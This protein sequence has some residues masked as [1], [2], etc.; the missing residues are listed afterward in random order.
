MPNDAWNF[1]IDVGGTFTD[2][3]ARRP[4]GAVVTHKVLSSGRVKGRVEA[5]DGAALRDG[6]RRGETDGLYAGY[7]F[8]LLD[9]EGRERAQARV[10]AFDGS[11]GTLRLD[12]QLDAMPGDSYE[13]CSGEPAPVLAIRQL[14]G[15]RLG[16]D[17]GAID[18]RLGT[19]RGTNALLERKGAPTAFVTTLGFADILHIG[20]QDRPHLFKLKIEKSEA[21]FRESVELDERLDAGG[22]VLKALDRDEVERKLRPLKARGI[23]ALAVCLLHAYRNPAHEEL[24]AKVARELGFA[25]VSISSSVSRTIKLVSRADTTVVDA[26]LTPVIRAYVEQIRAPM[27]AASLRLITSAGGLV[28]PEHFSG[29]ESILSGPAGGVVGF[30]SAAREAGFERAIGFDMGG[31]ST[32]VSRFDGAYEYQF[33][34]VKAGV[35]VV[36]PM[37]AIETVAAGGGSVCRFD[38]QKLVVGPESAGADPGPA[39]YG[40]GGP[41][42]VTDLNV[43]LGKDPPETFPFP[44]RV[45]AIERRIAELAREVEAATGRALAPRELAEGFLQIANANMAAPIKKISIARGYDVRQY[46]LVSFGGAG[47]QHACAVA[48]SLGI[49]TVLLHPHAGVLSAFGM[50]LADVKRFGET[51]LLAPC[52]EAALR[53]LSDEFRRMEAELRAQLREEGLPESGIGAPRP[54]L[55]MRY[56]GQSAT[57]AVEDSG[58]YADPAAAARRLAEAFEVLHRERY[59]HAQEGRAIEIV[60]ARLE[61]SGALDRHPAAWREPVPHRP[62]PKAR[63]AVVFQGR[64]HDAGVFARSD[65]RP[66]DAL[67]GPAI[68]L[69][70]TS[71]IAVDPGWEAELSGRGDLLLTDREGRAERVEVSTE[72]DPIRLEIFHNHFASIAEQMGTVLQRTALSTNVKERL[73]FSCAVFTAG[74]ELV[75]NAPHIP[76]H[77]GAMGECVKRLIADMPGL[78]PGDAVVT[79]DPFRGGSHLPDV[80]VVTPVFDPSGRRLFF[81]ASRAHHAEIGGTRP[82][83]MP[84]DSKRLSEEGVLIRQFKILDA[85]VSREADLRRLLVEAPYPSRAPDENLADIRAQLAANRAGAQDLLRM[86]ERYG[87]EV[88]L[89]YMEHIRAASEAKLRAALSRIPGGVH[90]FVDELDDGSP[91]AVAVTVKGDEAVIDFSGTGPVIDG[92]LNANRAI[93]TSAVLYALRCLI[94]EDIPLNGG[95]LAPVTLVLPECLLN[96]PEHDDP[97]RCAAIVGGNVE[98]SQRVVD[99]LLG[100]LGLC[101]A[102]QGTMNNFLF[103]DE[104]FGY[105]ETI[106]GGAGA[107]PGFDGA[108]AVHTHMTNTRLTDPEVFEARYPVRLKRFAIRANSGGAGRWRGGNGIVREVEFLKDLDVSLLTGRRTSQPYGLQGGQPGAP[109]KNLLRRAGQTKDEELPWRAMLRV[110]AGDTITILTPGGGG[111]HR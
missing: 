12:A 10:A 57:L 87:A 39:C 25:Q 21:L 46:A 48:R 55:E 14:M 31:T 92:N 11:S 76:V 49:K 8:A 77:L 27:P 9:A 107:G 32:D 52:A 96:P 69:E 67:A 18:V 56:T 41:L 33:E 17:L 73:D 90:A 63:R 91:I 44:L 54:I 68:V 45:E 72:A 13:L 89:A 103:G 4:D 24:V 97:A 30:S 109:G 83:S 19:T 84:P 64:E 58:G 26:Y 102:S 108:D 23:E 82:G 100:A 75:A 28:R 71:T 16:E 110:H 7:A 38:G 35:R 79:N 111:Y 65:L 101:A 88:V 29:K 93:V 59:G 15:K 20:T 99:V 42:A 86:A 47:A 106:C 22:R 85:G 3:V 36:A 74:G 51:T 80:T 43:Y 34:T 66:G 2:V 95:V 104:R 98:T 6:A 61:L 50:S 5:L 53:R 70:S 94:D 1:C 78:R 37:L 60:T 105:Y 40:R 81:T 62:D